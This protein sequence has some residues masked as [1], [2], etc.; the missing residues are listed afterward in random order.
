MCT[1]S[2]RQFSRKSLLSY[3]VDCH[4]VT[5]YDL[6]ERDVN[7]KSK[8]DVADCIECYGWSRECF[9]YLTA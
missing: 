5:E 6:E 7:T 8:D 3:I 2:I 4:G 1:P 9:D